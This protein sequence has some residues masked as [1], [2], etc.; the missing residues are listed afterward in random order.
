MQESSGMNPHEALYTVAQAV[1]PGGIS[2][3]IRLNK[4]LG[5]AVLHCPGPGGVRLRPRGREYVDLLTSHG[6]TILGHNHPGI[7][8]ATT[9]S[10]TGSTKG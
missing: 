1:L 4:A 5:E 6:A 8:A 3:S 9:P 7:R 10:P 2:S